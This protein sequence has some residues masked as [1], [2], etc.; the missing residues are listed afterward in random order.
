MR[1]HFGWM[2]AAALAAT[3]ASSAS[4]ESERRI[5]WGGYLESRFYWTL[6]PDDEVTLGTFSRARLEL[7]A[8]SSH[9]ASVSVVI[10]GLRSTGDFTELAPPGGADG[11]LP[12]GDA[13]GLLGGAADEL[14]IDRAHL[15]VRF[16]KLDLRVGRQRIFWGVA[17]VWTTLDVFNPVT[18]LEPAAEKPGVEAVRATVPLGVLTYLEG[19]GIPAGRMEDATGALRLQTHM[20][21][22]DAGLNAIHDGDRRENVAGVDLRSELEAGFWLE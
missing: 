4:A 11:A 21:G 8:R 17:H 5:D 20:F 18:P 7:D 12:A 13:A 22:F 10:E 2:V 19:V 14:R 16:P 1:R 9:R 15:D 3:L 6:R